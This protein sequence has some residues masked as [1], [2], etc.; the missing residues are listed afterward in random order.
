[1]ERALGHACNADGGL[2]PGEATTAPLTVRWSTD[3][4]PDPVT[5]QTV[6]A[7]AAADAWRR[8]FGRGQGQPDAEQPCV[9]E[10]VDPT[11]GKAARVDLALPEYREMFQGYPTPSSV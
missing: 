5:E 4:N 11:S 1:M 6:P 2:D 7:H 3:A 8:T 10:V 9:F